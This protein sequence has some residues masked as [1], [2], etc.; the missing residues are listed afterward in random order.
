MKGDEAA[1]AEGATGSTSPRASCLHLYFTAL[2]ISSGASAAQLADR[3]TP[4]ER[5][6]ESERV[7]VAMA[8][9][10]SEVFARINCVCFG[11]ERNA[12]LV[13]SP[14]FSGYFYRTL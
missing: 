5:E 9:L 10:P 12:G 14:Y 6:R 3:E 1:G 11:P 4:G 13:P 8:P 2:S 7:T